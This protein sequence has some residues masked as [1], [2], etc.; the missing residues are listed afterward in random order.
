MVIDEQTR[1]A[2]VTQ[3]HS[4]ENGEKILLYSSEYFPGLKNYYDFPSG[5]FKIKRG[6]KIDIDC[7]FK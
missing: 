1:P 3:R 5:F 4:I 2:Y 6:T 7:T